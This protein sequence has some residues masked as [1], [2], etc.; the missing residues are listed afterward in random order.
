MQEGNFI[1]AVLD[2]IAKADARELTL[3][4]VK[5][6]YDGPNPETM[7]EKWQKFYGGQSRTLWIYRNEL[8]RESQCDAFAAWLHKNF[9]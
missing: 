6:F 1:R 2:A 7:L 5:S 8:Y 4:D 3:D 9:M